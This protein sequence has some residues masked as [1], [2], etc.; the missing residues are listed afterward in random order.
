MG[1]FA[2]HESDFRFLEAGV[3]VML[4]TLGGIRL[5]K[6]MIPLSLELA[7]SHSTGALH[8]HEG[9]AHGLAYG[10]GLIHGLA[11]SGALIL[12]VLTQIKGTGAGMLY[13]ILFGVGSM[14]GMMVAAG[15]FSVPFSVRL[16]TNS[17]VRTTLVVLSSMVCIG[18]GATVV[19]ENALT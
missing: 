9:H 16:L 7:H 5:Y 3:G 18:L 2:L 17:M 13:L 10:V 1:K 6:L 4:M 15:V 11:G 12:S 14:V 8:S 19:Y